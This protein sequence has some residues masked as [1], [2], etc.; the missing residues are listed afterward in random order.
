MTVGAISD[1]RRALG[2][3]AFG[4]CKAKF[5]GSHVLA[6]CRQQTLLTPTLLRC[7]QDCLAICFKF[8][9]EAKRI[10]DSPKRKFL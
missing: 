10:K 8:K 5:D 6:G 9:G 1:G 2:R 3:G 7:V 4:D